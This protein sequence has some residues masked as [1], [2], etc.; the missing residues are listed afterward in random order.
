MDVRY[1]G[2][3]LRIHHSAFRVRIVKIDFTNTLHDTET[4][5]IQRQYETREMYNASNESIWVFARCI[6]IEKL[7][8]INWAQCGASPKRN[9][10]S[11]QNFLYLDAPIRPLGA[12]E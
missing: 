7:V 8:L 1:L 11:L 12:I 2:T 4:L 10:C 9:T 6:A 5:H 3:Y